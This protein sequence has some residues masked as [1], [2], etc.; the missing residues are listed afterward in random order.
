M[1]HNT[2]AARS[3]RRPKKENW[4]D[5]AGGRLGSAG[6]LGSDMSEKET[7]TTQQ[8]VGYKRWRA[9]SG[10]ARCFG[11]PQLQLPLRTDEKTGRVKS[12]C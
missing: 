7:K 3:K 4:P 10:R 8:G 2:L 5:L 9:A 6:C 1:H 11:Q 12:R